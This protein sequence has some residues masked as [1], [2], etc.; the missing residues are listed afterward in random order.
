MLRHLQWCLDLVK[1]MQRFQ[2]WLS[3][4]FSAPNVAP[5]PVGPTLD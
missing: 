5:T 2:R 3:W 1:L 4:R